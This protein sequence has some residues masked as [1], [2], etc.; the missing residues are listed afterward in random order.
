MNYTS[1]SFTAQ[2][3]RRLI[4]SG[5]EHVYSVI[6]RGSF[7][8]YWRK[9][10][11]DHYNSFFFT[12]V[13]NGN[14][15]ALCWNNELHLILFPRISQSFMVLL[16]T[17]APT[18][19]L[20]LVKKHCASPPHRE[21][22]VSGKGKQYLASTK[23]SKPRRVLW[24]TAKVALHALFIKSFSVKTFLTESETSFSFNFGRASERGIQRSEVRFLMGAQNFFFVPRS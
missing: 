12:L 17:Q 15:D 2:S 7:H 1:A 20:P 3:F 4:C 24:V 16:F 19:F 5:E 22:L 11:W 6:K 23:Q 18:T 10:V 13:T 14:F 21:K 8:Q 9:F